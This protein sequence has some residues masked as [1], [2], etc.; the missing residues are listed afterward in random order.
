[1]DRHR[2]GARHR[3]GLPVDPAGIGHD[4]DAGAAGDDPDLQGRGGRREHIVERA[5]RD[6]ILVQAAHQPDEVGGEVHGVVGEIRP[7]GMAGAP[8]HREAAGHLALV[9]Q[10]R[11]HLRGLADEAGGG[12]G[13]ELGQPGDHVA[14]ADAADLLVV[15]QG[16]VDRPGERRTHHLGHERQQAGDE[17]LHVDGAA[18]DQAVAGLPQGEGVAGPALARRHHIEMARQDDPRHVARA[19]RREQ[20]GPV[21]LRPRQDRRLDAVA[22]EVVAHQR[23]DRAVRHAAHRGDRHEGGQEGGGVGH[24]ALADRRTARIIPPE[25]RGAPVE[26]GERYRRS[27]RRRRSGR[28]EGTVGSRRE[29][30]SGPCR[31]KQRPRTIQIVDNPTKMVLIVCAERIMPKISAVQHGAIAPRNGRRRQTTP[32]PS[33]ARGEDDVAAGRRRL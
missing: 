24:R 18:P 22:G 19:D 33:Q 13:A 30:G 12:G 9:A 3:A 29:P 7:R 4:V 2:V 15:G 6:E 20:V 23:D 5:P 17:A 21:A 27:C 31:R 10:D 14:H 11:A 8:P 25:R 28:H 16:E 1:M 26:G 32:P